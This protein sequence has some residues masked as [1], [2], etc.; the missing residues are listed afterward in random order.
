L[1]TRIGVLTL[2]EDYLADPDGARMPGSCGWFTSKLSFIDWSSGS[3][4]PPH[5]LWLSGEAGTGKSVLSSHIVRHIESLELNCSYFFFKESSSGRSYVRDCLRSLAFQM[6]CSN[7]S[8]RS[9]LLSLGNSG[10]LGDRDDE[11][12][13][14]RKL[15]LRCLF[16]V[17]PPQTNFWVIDALD[18]CSNYQSLFPLLYQVPKHFRI[19]ITSRVV[20]DVEHRF[21]ALGDLV[22]HQHIRAS[23]T[24]DDVKMFVSSRLPASSDK[25]R[26]I[27]KEQIIS[28]SAGSFLW[29]RLVVEELMKEKLSEERVESVLNEV[30]PDMG[31]LY[32]GML[33]KMVASRGAGLAKTLLVWSVCALRPMS[34]YELQWALKM[35]IN[36]TVH[37]LERSIAS[38]CG[39]L[40]TVD[41]NSRV[42]IVHQIARRFLLHQ[43]K[44]LPFVINKEQSHSRLASVCLGFLSGYLLK[45]Q[46]GWSRTGILG[47]GPG[48]GLKGRQELNDSELQW[49]FADYACHFFSDHLYKSS[50]EGLTSLSALCAFF[51]KNALAWIEYI[52]RT[53]DLSRLVLTAKNL[54]AFLERHADHFPPISGEVKTVEAWITDLIRVTAKFRAQL[55]ASPSSIYSLIPPMCPTESIIG[56]THRTD[57]RRLLISGLEDRNW[58]DCLARI[59]FPSAQTSGAAYGDRLFAVGLSNGRIHLYDGSSLQENG[60]LEH[61]ERIRNLIFAHDDKMLASSSLR[62]VR[63]WD[64]SSRSLT[65]SWCPSSRVI[66][67]AFMDDDRLIH[68]ASVDNCVRAVRTSDGIEVDRVNLVESPHDD[69]LNRRPNQSPALA[70]FSSDCGLLAVCYRGR[71]ILVFEER[72]AAPL[73]YVR[74]EQPSPLGPIIQYGVDAIAFNPSLEIDVLIASYGDGELTVYDLLSTEPKHRLYDVFAHSL[75]C[76]PDGRSLIT[77]TSQGSIQIFSFGGACGDQLSILYQIEA[78]EHGIKALS[79]SQDSL[80][81]MDIRASQCRVW[82]PTILVRK[83]YDDGS[84][85]DFSQPFQIPRKVA[86]TI[87]DS[88]S[89]QITAICCHPKG[90]TLF[91]GRQDGTVLCYS[92]VDGNDAGIL[93]SHSANVGVVFLILAP[94]LNDALVSVLA[95]A[96]ESGRILI[97]KLVKEQEQWSECETLADVLMSESITSLLVNPTADRLLVVGEKNDILLDSKGNLIRNKDASGSRAAIC[98]LQHE[99]LF[100]VLWP[101][102]ARLFRWADFQEVTSGNGIE[103]QR[104]GNPTIEVGATSV[105][106][107]GYPFLT[108]FRYGIGYGSR[109]RLDRWRYSGLEVTSNSVTSIEGFENLGPRI[110]HVISVGEATLYFLD[111]DLWVC[112]LNFHNFA[113]SRQVKRHF[114]I[115]PEW[116]NRTGKW[117]VHLTSKREFV[118]A[119][120]DRVVI[121]KRGLEFANIVKY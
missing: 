23:D 119:K 40:L 57:R 106:V 17:E 54:K 104:A 89:P 69:F 43:K 8:S 2:P 72:D 108:E 16:T 95:S 59:D 46:R 74:D 117:I 118:F 91:C 51:N 48:V 12:D 19:F 101:R 6:A 41:H 21:A 120:Q 107:F 67:L 34:V 33:T 47:L 111:V 28:K 11:R 121:V 66:S 5:I 13:I 110:E 84:S 71:P 87:E 60:I 25:N 24:L 53:G 29:V 102:V 68:A 10:V 81:F 114:F 109:S 96:D 75:V 78:H 30:L 65:W 85:T 93:F 113:E 32:E 56:R 58:D 73:S 62:L 4:D 3:G 90:K 14:W 88:N 31:Q 97:K 94:T 86:S 52:S 39:Q 99:D 105:S 116:R 61:G 26:A 20:H 103:L 83:D 44:V 18:E 76:S 42:Q 63:L 45:N 100:I 49:A 55:L 37:D 15:F 112:S 1:K 36:E 115:L 9:Q 77:G 80:R 79:F 98:H 50:S 92:T 70:V 64:P 27:L 7:G 35:D 82:E 22:L 38:I